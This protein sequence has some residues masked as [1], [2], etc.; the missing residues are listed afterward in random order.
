MSFDTE[1]IF[2]LLNGCNE[3]KIA[4]ILIAANLMATHDPGIEESRHFFCK[5]FDVINPSLLLK[6]IE[7]PGKSPAFREA[8]IA[9]ISNS[10]HLG[11]SYIF[12]KV[13]LRLIDLVFSSMTSGAILFKKSDVNSSSAAAHDEQFQL[14]LFLIMKWIASGINSRAVEKMLLHSLHVAGDVNVDLPPYFV[15]AFL[16]FL[17]DLSHLLCCSNSSGEVVKQMSILPT[18]SVR[19][20]RTT[21]IKGFHGG[22]PERI[23]DCSLMCC[24]HFLSIG[25][26]FQQSW[27]LEGTEYISPEEDVAASHK[28]S[29]GNF[30]KL[31][32]SVIG[33]EVHLLLEEALALFKQAQ[34][35]PQTHTY[36]DLRDPAVERRKRY[37]EVKIDPKNSILSIRTKRLEEMIPCCMSLINS[38]LSLLVGG[39]DD[40]PDR[41]TAT[42]AAGLTS[43]TILHMRQTMHN[44]FQKIFDFLKE[45]SDISDDSTSAVF[46]GI[47]DQHAVNC[48][49]MEKNNLLIHIVREATATLCLWVLEDGDLREPF[50]SNL[51]FILTWSAVTHHM[52]TDDQI[53]SNTTNTKAGWKTSPESA[54][55]ALTTYHGDSAAR[56]NGDVG[57]VLHYVLP[58][59]VSIST[60]LTSNDELSDKIC[61]LDGGCLMSRLVN[62]AV[63]IGSHASA[64]SRRSDV[65]PVESKGGIATMHNDTMELD[66]AEE[67]RSRTSL[68]EE[69]LARMNQTCCAAID[70]LTYILSWKMNEIRIL[71][72]GETE[73]EAFCAVFALTKTNYPIIPLNFSPNTDILSTGTSNIS[74]SLTK[75]LEDA[76]QALSAD[77]VRSNS[78]SELR[79]S[80]SNLVQVL[81]SI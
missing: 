40:R 15:A 50:L 51:P 78:V 9:L 13:T 47:N 60:T 32:V 53:S 35:E 74:E 66:V 52:Y 27:T 2:C 23:R 55:M 11:F 28:E 6:I 29:S 45:I 62:I 57:D 17:A 8:G 34:G 26:S 38:I 77:S 25:C 79:K 71:K 37:D 61:T 56:S 30:L 22:A 64:L 75:I 70:Q 39:N 7:D 18:E 67:H 21:L 42:S 69:S 58:C 12:R 43:S 80:I 44:T 1:G 81:Q 49:I 48:P 20:L 24:A 68:N 4:G 73:S 14:D 41:P 10:I 59:L 46:G 65:C 63:I 5:M 33:I 3:E 72:K 36:G 54:W 19:N 76:S 31:L 16:D